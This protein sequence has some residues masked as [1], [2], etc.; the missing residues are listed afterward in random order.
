MYAPPSEAETESVSNK[1]KFKKNLVG[2]FWD[3]HTAEQ[4]IWADRYALV[5]QRLDKELDEKKLDKMIS[6]WETSEDC[7]RSR[8]EDIRDFIDT[9]EMAYEAVR[10]VCDMVIPSL[11][12]AFMLF[13]RAEVEDDI[14][15]DLILSKLDYEDEETLYDQMGARLMEVLGGEPGTPRHGI[16]TDEVRNTRGDQCHVAEADRRGPPGGKS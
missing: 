5:K 4:V 9:F 2:K 1:S 3:K 13:R 14:R 11:I 6:R 10:M 15:R 16:E 7:K 12:T 8:G